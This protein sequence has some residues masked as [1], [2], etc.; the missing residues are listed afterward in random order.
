MLK[1]KMKQG[2]FSAWLNSMFVFRQADRRDVYP[3]VFPPPPPDRGA[4]KKP[5]DIMPNLTYFV[6]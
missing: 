2:G 6:K 5:V 3:F 1:A 4:I